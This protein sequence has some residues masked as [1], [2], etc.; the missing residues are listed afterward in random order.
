MQSRNNDKYNAIT[1]SKDLP[2]QINNLGDF[3]GLSKCKKEGFVETL[4]E[5]KAYNY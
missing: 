2:E 5:I 4:G 1:N 3:L